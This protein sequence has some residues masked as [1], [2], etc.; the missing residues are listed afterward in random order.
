MRHTSPAKPVVKPCSDDEISV[1]I[2][3]TSTNKTIPKSLITI[4]GTYL[5]ERQIKT[6]LEVY[7]NC[8]ILLACG[9]YADKI[10]DT[11]RHKYPLRIIYNSN[12]IDNNAMCGVG[13]ALQATPNKNILL[14]SSETL[15][16]A[17]ALDGICS[18]SSKILVENLVSN[19]NEVGATC[20]YNKV[21]NLAYGLPHRFCNIAFINGKELSLLEKVAFDKNAARWFI[22]EGL[23]YIIGNGG[24]LSKH[25]HSQSKTFN[26]ATLKQAEV[27]EQS[28]FS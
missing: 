2:P 27:A 21:I 28:F 10:R 24:A 15:F 6:I 7:P 13:L 17:Y 5:L 19:D 23:N 1:I 18:S 8:E 12:D 9:M 26:V 4:A 14:I 11:F 3:I 20:E 25:S 22:Y 16:N